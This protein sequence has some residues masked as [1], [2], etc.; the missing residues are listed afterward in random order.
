MEI[1]SEENNNLDLNTE[2]GGNVSMDSEQIN[3]LQNQE[4]IDYSNRM[5]YHIRVPYESEHFAD[6]VMKSIGVDAP[7]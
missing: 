1:D 5:K 4:V 3:N 2:N 7:Y 6:T